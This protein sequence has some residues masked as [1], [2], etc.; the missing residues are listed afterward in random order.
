MVSNKASLLVA[1]VVPNELSY[2]N[3]SMCKRVGGLIGAFFPLA[4]YLTHDSICHGMSENSGNSFLSHATV[5][6]TPCFNENPGFPKIR[7]VSS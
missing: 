6:E 3:G 4:S 7:K 1:E 5:C 2:T